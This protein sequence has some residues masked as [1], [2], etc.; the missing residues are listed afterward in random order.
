MYINKAG[1]IDRPYILMGILIFMWGSFSAVSKLVLVGLDSFQVQFYMFGLA[2]VIMTVIMYFSGKLGKFRSI[3][4]KDLIKLILYALPSFFYSFLYIM[5]LGMI[6]TIEASMLNYLFPIMIVIF[7]IP[8][9]KERLD[10]SKLLSVIFGF[11][12]M[13]IIT[14]NGN[15]HSLKLSNIRGDML[16]IAAS[17][18]WGI[19]SNLGKRNK[20]D[21]ELSNYVYILVSFALSIVSLMLFSEF[22]IP[23]IAA[24]SGV[25]WISLSNIVFAYYMWFRVLKV[26]SLAFAASF[27]FVIPFVSLGF[28]MLLLGEKI[29]IIQVVGF[30]L[31]IVGIAAQNLIH[32]IKLQASHGSRM[33]QNNGK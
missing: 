7:A 10:A 9:N 25:L 17:I 29:S 20:I 15:F 30:I 21:Q 18:C 24:F 16:A 2:A 31:I 14:T 13:L 22:V 4:R 11:A 12:G 32:G 8:I 19:F 5:A 6:P 27:S 23:D 28:I 3:M 1:R 26:T 33:N